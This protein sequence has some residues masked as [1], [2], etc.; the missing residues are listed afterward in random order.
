MAGI[1]NPITWI[2][3]GINQAL[4]GATPNAPVPTAPPPP[5][6]PTY[7]PKTEEVIAILRNNPTTSEQD[8]ATVLNLSLAAATPF[9]EDAKRAL[10][11][12]K[13]TQP[14]DP[15]TNNLALVPTAANGTVV[16]G[17]WIDTTNGQEAVALPQIIVR[18][19]EHRRTAEQFQEDAE[20]WAD[21]AVRIG[22]KTLM[23][24]GPV[25]LAFF[26]AMLIGEQYA[27]L[28]T[29]FWW[30]PAMYAV[31]TVT[32]FSLW[33]TSFGASREFRRL[34]SD[35]SRIPTFVAL[36]LFFLVF[37][38]MSILAQWF[39]YEG[40]FKSPDF[41]TT[42]GIVFRT[43]S[44]TGVDILALL[45]LGVLDFR[46]FKAHLKKQQMVAEQIQRLSRTEIDT[47]RMQQEEVIRQQKA[48]IEKERELKHAQFFADME[49]KQIDRMKSGRE[50]RG[51][52]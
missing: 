31:A 47:N 7:D 30:A 9:I 1:G 51:R 32:E 19:E 12:E 42:I 23:Y 49:G 40:H 11:K 41:P 17:T 34:L 46:S 28:S 10:L 18:M 43:C 22:V 33:G 52:W 44:T 3:N 24:V 21:K 5:P 35:R 13:L 50:E 29:D 6:K 37:S 27:K 15:T 20:D 45:V 16:A 8:I 39:V 38:G 36:V 26:I 48:E 25:T 4:N 14:A 2:A